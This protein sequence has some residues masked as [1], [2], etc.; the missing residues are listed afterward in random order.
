MKRE[1]TITVAGQALTL[2]TDENERYLKK[3]AEHVDEHMKELTR[4]QRG[5]TTLNVAI[6]A[7]LNVADEY[8]KL[9]E[10][11]EEAN[12][13]IDALAGEL[14]SSMAKAAG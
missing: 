8:F 4:G 5:T 3:L 9:R 10:A 1:V 14:E 11:A 13:S 7:A 12:A 2:R 6:L